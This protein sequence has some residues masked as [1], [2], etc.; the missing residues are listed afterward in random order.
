MNNLNNIKSE[1]DELKKLKQQNE[2]NQKNIKELQE[3]L[4]ILEEEKKRNE[5]AKKGEKEDKQANENIENLKIKIFEYTK[6]KIETDKEIDLHKTILV[7]TKEKVDNYINSGSDND[8]IGFVDYCSENYEI[9]I[10]YIR[11]KFI[12]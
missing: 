5:E 4:K 7:T 9:D 1:E 10:D 3:K 2:E 12:N 8:D 11:E 6:K